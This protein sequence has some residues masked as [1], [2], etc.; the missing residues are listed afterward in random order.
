M[1]IGNIGLNHKLAGLELRENLARICQKWFGP[2]QF[3]SDE[4][5]F[6]LLS[7]CNRTEVYFSS[8][9]L[10][11]THGHLLNVLR[12]EIREDFDQ[13]LYSYFSFDCF[14]HLT[15]VTAG[16]DSAILA[17]TEVQGQ[18][19][20]AYENALL[21]QK[22]PSELHFLF[23]KAMKIAKQVRNEI[24]MG[25]G[26]PDLEDA[27][28]QLGLQEFKGTPPKILFIGASSINEKILKLLKA[29]NFNSITL[30]NRSIESSRKL[31]Q[32]YQIQGLPWNQLNT[33]NQYDWIICA[34]KAP[35]Y[36]LTSNHVSF[37]KKLLIDLSVP[38][39]IEPQIGNR[40]EH[41]LLNIDQ[42]NEML[43]TRRKQL[44]SQLEE[45]ELLIS[46]T[47]HTQIH[48]YQEKQQSKLRILAAIA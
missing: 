27:I 17:E 48:T 46:Q 34:T 20:T 39:N 35:D 47:V 44:N 38:R 19:K 32:E 3:S 2:H 42:I 18:V 22:L 25:R 37:G 5:A 13:K 30:C 12:Q 15:R 14:Y 8:Y 28:F 16:L 29:K 21:C 10:P 4:H 40:K 7:T 1:R 9:D 31:E 23:Q 43:K 41:I 33:W 26:V 24:P 36:L 45:A 11:F 6:V